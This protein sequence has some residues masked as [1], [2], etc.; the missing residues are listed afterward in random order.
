M[1]AGGLIPPGPAWP[2]FTESPC[3][4][5]LLLFRLILINNFP[6]S[7]SSASCPDSFFSPVCPLCRSYGARRHHP[8]ETPGPWP[9]CAPTHQLPPPGPPGTAALGAISGPS[10]PAQ[11]AAPST[12]FALGHPD[13]PCLCW[14]LAAYQTA[15]LTGQQASACPSEVVLVR[16]SLDTLIQKSPV[17]P[18][19][20]TRKFRILKRVLGPPWSWPSFDLVSQGSGC[21]AGPPVSVRVC[22]LRLCT[23]LTPLGALFPP[24]QD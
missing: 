23:S 1:L 19:C 8:V 17:A 4:P 24:L 12:L 18:R 5:C 15:R 22:V 21:T 13:P 14:A 7:L 2:T 9:W 11:L 10:C 3:S 16:Q 20:C 6:G